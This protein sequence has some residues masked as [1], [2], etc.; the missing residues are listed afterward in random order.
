M[1]E[2]YLLRDVDHCVLC[3]AKGRSLTRD[4]MVPK[5][6]GRQYDFFT[7]IVKDA[8]NLIPVC[9]KEH[10]AIDLQKI[11]AY[12][13]NGIS[14]LVDYLGRDYPISPEEDTAVMQRR[15][16]A[17]V[18]AEIVVK[19]VELNGTINGSLA[20]DFDRAVDLANLH[21]DRF[22]SLGIE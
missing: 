12:R 15:H 8:M 5:I 19:R 21:I 2:F 4:H 1:G 3:S 10:D 6:V 22:V 16:L 20:L 11:D 7:G 14:G 9:R 17:Y 13:Q 18:L